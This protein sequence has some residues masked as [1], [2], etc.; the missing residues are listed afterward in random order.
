MSRHKTRFNESNEIEI[1]IVNLLIWGGLTLLIIVALIGIFTGGSGNSSSG[2]TASP[3]REI[4]ITNE[5]D[6]VGI[7]DQMIRQ[8]TDASDAEEFT[9]ALSDAEREWRQSK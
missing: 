2:Y 3:S 9:R 4:D 5:T 7:R 1:D 8:G 6:R